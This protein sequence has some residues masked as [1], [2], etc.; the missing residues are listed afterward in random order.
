MKIKEINKML[1]DKNISL[2][3]KITLEKK[4]EILIN[5]KEIKK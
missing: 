2:K 4:K 5:N 1:S 3:M